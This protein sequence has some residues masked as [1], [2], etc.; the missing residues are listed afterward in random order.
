MRSTYLFFTKNKSGKK[1]V[2]P[3]CASDLDNASVFVKLLYT[4]YEV[5]L[6]L[7]D[8]LHVTS[9]TYCHEMCEVQ[10]QLTDLAP[11]EDHVLSSTTV[12]MKRKYDKYWGNVD[13]INC[14]FVVYCC[15]P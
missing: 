2:G 3:S 4:F 14:L 6:T 5:I 7:S 10:S 13:E 8:S 11:S 9:N 1:R 15:C 12:S